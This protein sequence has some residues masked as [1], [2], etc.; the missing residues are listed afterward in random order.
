MRILFVGL[1][2]IGTRHLKNVVSELT[3]RNI[4]FTIDALR[5]TNNVLGSDIASNICKTYMDFS[6]I[7]EIYDVTFITNPTYMHYETLKKVAP[8]S[9]AV[10]IE[11]PLFC[12]TKVDLDAL[13]LVN[14]NIYYI[15][16]PLRRSPVIRRMKEIAEKSKV[17]AVRAICS[18]Y[19]P[20]W[21]KNTD[22]RNSYSAHVEEGGGVRGDL[23][24]E[25]D[26]IIDIFGEP[27]SASSYSSKISALEIDSDDIALYNLIYRDKVVSLH[28]DYFGRV[29]RRELEF[30]TEEDTIIGDIV[31]G[32]VTW[33]KTGVVEKLAPI[34]I[35]KEEIHYFFDL[36]QG[37]ESNIND[38]NRAFGV[39]QIAQ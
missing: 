20:D 7:E 21:R 23:I 11:K 29:P 26:Y 19:L 16:C 39:L 10:L 38:I 30:F 4:S 24:H 37:K 3:N 13:G 18:S 2:S 8:V 31:K 1:G 6:E 22:Y 17:Y 35:H 12:D 34:D 9:R 15:A 27:T 28:L 33:L 36:V 5:T 25:M 14:E 32:T